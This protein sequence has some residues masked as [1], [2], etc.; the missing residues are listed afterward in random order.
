MEFAQLLTVAAIWS[1][2][3]WPILQLAIGLG[4]VI[5]FHE[6]GHFLLAKA[7]GIKVERFAIG[8]GPRV[9]GLRKGETDYCLCALPLG[10]YVKML[11]QDDFKPQD[12]GDAGPVEPHAAAESS[13]KPSGDPRSYGSK[14]VGARFA[15]ISAG[16]IMNVIL[17]AL[18]FV[19]VCLVGIRFPAPV[20]GSV[21]PG[22][23][24]DEAEISWQRPDRVAPDAP[25][26]P[27]TGLKPGDD[28]GEISGDGLLASLL[29]GDVT[30][31]DRIFVLA[32]LA[33]RNET[34]RF[35]FTRQFEGRQWTGL[36]TMGVQRMETER[37]S[38]RF[39]FG[40]SS[41]NSLQ[42]GA[43]EDI[44]TDSE[45]QPLDE[46]LAIAG[47]PVEHHWQ[48]APITRQLTGQPVEVRVR[49]HEDPENS[50][51]PATETTVTVRPVLRSLAMRQGRL[52]NLYADANQQVFPAELERTE[53]R[54]EQTFLTLRRPDG[55]TQ[56]YSS[57]EVTNISEHLLDIL[58]MVPRLTVSGVYVGSPADQAGLKPG[59]IIVN[60]AER[61]PPT[62]V[63]LHTLND[64]IS[65][66]GARTS[67]V[68]I[69]DGN[70]LPAREIAPTRRDGSALIGISPG[71]DLAHPVVGHVR[72]GS[73]ANQAG[74]LP[75]ATIQAVNDQPVANWWELYQALAAIP[76]GQ[77]A[78][79]ATST[80]TIELDAL[81]GE[82]FSPD[83][84]HTILFDEE[85]FLP[86]MG[87][88]IRRGPIAALA[89][90]TRET[91]HFVIATYGTLKGL[92]FGTV[93]PKELHGP[94]GITQLAIRVGRQDSIARFI[95]FLAMIS[96]SLAVV[97]FLPIP[98]VDGG[99]A[100]L[101]LV[102]KLRGKP[103]PV[104]V[105]NVI[106]MAG[107]ALLLLA[108]VAIT[109][110]DV[111]RIVRSLW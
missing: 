66:Q 110:N 99:H 54:D 105:Q 77:P 65:E 62:M 106:Q 93:S 90:G 25:T 59:D 96:V 75:G 67:I 102:E 19:V 68:L 12:E 94:V 57:E 83:N 98:V 33:D 18:L 22:F 82:L 15:V 64:K 81:G 35:R 52:W 34:F 43:Y 36:A 6:L 79:L 31:F 109:F 28:I 24:A 46:V 47:Q 108:F 27:E 87:P 48:V 63:D 10:G 26:P 56:T 107:L 76:A 21:A 37:G 23:P 50:E 44:V 111:T 16:V 97:N 17:A 71:L 5:F 100:V 95:Y 78:S 7:V 1:D 51:S 101:L 92:L 9:I 38:E 45:F 32:S 89:W 73:P 39:A 80:G 42:I 61:G 4:L 55:Q 13:D 72:E 30:R 29:G 2:W 84:Y 58:G 91:V 60:Y 85:G 41:A 70:M 14:S 11:G 74:V 49:R 8:M 40:I 20:V 103:V 86:L 69:R 3:L 104:R 53:K 88:E